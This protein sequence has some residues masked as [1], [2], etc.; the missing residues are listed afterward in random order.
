MIAQVEA[1]MNSVERL[2]YYS[3]ELPLESQVVDLPDNPSSSHPELPSDWPARGEIV[4]TDVHM[5]YQDG[6]DVLKGLSFSVVSKEKI[7]IAG[8]T[9][10]GKS[11]LMT[12][13]FRI[14]N[15]RGSI[16]I[17]IN[18]NLIII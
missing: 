9:G 16:K 11:S 5:N 8:R 2:Q 14:E 1:N 3:F 7:G 10:S 15:I 12:A 18:H 17:G 4:A 6:P 13:L